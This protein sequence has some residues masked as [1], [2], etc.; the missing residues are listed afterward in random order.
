MSR[1]QLQ[2]FHERS[3]R[4]SL[5]SWQSAERRAALEMSEEEAAYSTL[6]HGG[7]WARAREGSPLPPDLERLSMPERVQLVRAACRFTSG[8]SLPG[9]FAR[10]FEADALEPEEIEEVEHALAQIDGLDAVVDVSVRLVDPV[11]EQED[12]LLLELAGA[13]SLVGDLVGQLSAR[14]DLAALASRFLLAQ[15]EPRYLEGDRPADW[16]TCL[17][18][19]DRGF[20]DPAL[21]DLLRGR[22]HT[23]TEPA[24]LYFPLLGPALSEYEARAVPLGMA[25]A[26][27]QDRQTGR[28]QALLSRREF[29]VEGDEAVLVRLKLI[30]PPARTSPMLEVLLETK[31][32]DGLDAISAY[33][34]FEV[35]VPGLAAPLRNRFDFDVNTVEFDARALEALRAGGGQVA[36]I[37][38]TTSGQRRPIRPR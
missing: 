33:E 27:T 26:G 20:D 12:G 11:I 1:D 38:V 32:A 5:D 36:V 19:L 29:E 28:E 34:A 15:R 23:T 22:P 10:L 6:E 13:R 14:P 30:L 4:D 2:A 37:L 24:A 17:R 35:R 3:C 9:H 25:A 31:E 18:E 8:F 7:L 21:G 16:F